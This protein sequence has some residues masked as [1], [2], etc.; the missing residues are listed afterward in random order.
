M[1]GLQKNEKKRDSHVCTLFSPPGGVQWLHGHNF[2]LFWPPPASM[3]KF[4]TLNTYKNRG[5]LPPTA[6]Y[7]PGSHWMHPLLKKLPHWLMNKSWIFSPKCSLSGGG[8][9]YLES[10]LLSRD[11]PF[12]VDLWCYTSKVT[13]LLSTFYP[14]RLFALQHCNRWRLE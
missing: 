6:S 13:I 10:I 4:L 2:L 1:S 14:S 3:W 9:E 5:F 11:F 12:G 8:H 7:C